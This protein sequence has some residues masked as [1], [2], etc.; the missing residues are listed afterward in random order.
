M[1][2]NNF[3]MVF[4]ITVARFF[5][6]FLSGDLTVILIL[7]YAQYGPLGYEFS[8]GALNSLRLIEILA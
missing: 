8:V 7:I 3:K 1:T 6:I 5:V 2:N 4:D